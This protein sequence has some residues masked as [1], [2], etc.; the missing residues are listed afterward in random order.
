MWMTPTG[1]NLTVN[2]LVFD[3]PGIS[4]YEHTCHLSTET[5]LRA[6]LENCSND[7]DVTIL[8][9]LDNIIPRYSE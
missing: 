9:R 8:S 4:N 5:I 7:A 6:D 3:S 2:L 1:S